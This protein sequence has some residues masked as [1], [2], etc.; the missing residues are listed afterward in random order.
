MKLNLDNKNTAEYMV[1]KLFE[2]WKAKD[3]KGINK[4]I[5]GTWLYHNS[6]KEFERVFGIY[7]LI[8]FYFYDKEIITNCRHEIDFR[9]DVILE[10]KTKS[11]Y[12]KANVICETAPYGP[13]PKG[14]WGVN[15]ISLLRW[16]NE[17]TR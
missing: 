7:K 1:S 15:P 4:Y 5:Q 11:L 8:D 10:D 16:H 3:F 2:G 13:S 12:G 9:V 17:N 6:K 14:K